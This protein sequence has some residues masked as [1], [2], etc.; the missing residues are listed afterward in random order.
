[1]PISE[2]AAD[3]AP[4]ARAAPAADASADIRDIIVAGG[5]IGGLTVALAL[6]RQGFSVTVLEQSAQL[7]EIGAGIQLAPNALRMLDTLG[8]LDA[9]YGDAVYPAE[10]VL[11]DAVT[12]ER[13]TALDFGP[14]FRE[15]YGYP[16]LVTHRSDLYSS[17]LSACRREQSLRIL[18]AKKAL[19][20]AEDDEVVTLTCADGSAF[21]CRALV[22]ADGI[23]SA[24]RRHVL[25]DS[26][27][28]CSGDAAYRGTV[29]S[30]RIADR[31]RLDRVTW[32]VG[33]HIH[34][35]Q[36]PV[37]QRELLN[38]VAVFSSAKFAAGDTGWGTPDELEDRF[39]G[40]ARPVRD[41]LALVGRDRAWQ[42]FDRDPDATWTRGRVTL[43]GDAAH[44]MLQYLAQGAC[45]A[46]ED[47]VVFA[48]CRARHRLVAK[49][50]RA[51]E[52]ERLPRTAMVQ[53]WARRMGEVVHAEGTMA[54]LRDALLKPR[55][56][57]DFTLFDWLYGYR[58]DH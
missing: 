27:P 36:Y 30:D 12:G 26:E 24:V 31:S 2:P 35:I 23:H 44:P 41:G 1:M 13:I 28:R 19:S 54:L 38:Q 3:S 42:L 33:P 48:E 6:A 53:T 7:R 58:N 37:R 16:Y 52:E 25:G 46:I 21:R 15:R 45:Q 57:D 22:G 50:L 14:G 40:T 55:R 11:I 5:G 51:Y 49:A 39:A 9:V 43:L 17:L 4:A 29:D 34:L 56:P 8:L 47:A 18:T 32:W 20:V 10:A